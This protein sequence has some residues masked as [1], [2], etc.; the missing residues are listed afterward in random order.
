MPAT[1]SNW[2]AILSLPPNSPINGCTPY[3]IAYRQ[4]NL[5]EGSQVFRVSHAGTVPRH[6][7]SEALARPLAHPIIVCILGGGEEGSIVIAMKRYI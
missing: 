7:N 1:T 5:V 6:I 4:D 3:L 2:S